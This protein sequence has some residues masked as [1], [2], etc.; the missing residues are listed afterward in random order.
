M[1]FLSLSLLGL[2]LLQGCGAGALPKHSASIAGTPAGFKA[3]QASTDGYQADTAF[4]EQQ[5]ERARRHQLHENTTWQRLVHYRPGVFYGVDSQVDGPAF[6]LS[7]KGPSDPAA[8][9]EATIRGFYSPP[10]AGQDHP[11]CRFPARWLWLRKHLGLSN[12]TLPTVNCAGLATYLERANTRSLTV[13]FSSYYLNNPASMFGHTFLRFN[14]G[15]DGP[16]ENR[17]LLEQGIDYSAAVPESENQL[18]YSFKGLT[19][20]YPG[21]F[22]MLPYYYKVREYNDFESRDLWEYDLA[23]DEEEV[24]MVVT[25]IWELG[26]SYFDYYYLSEN[27]S[28]HVLAAIEAANPRFNMLDRVGWPVIP[29]DTVKALMQE[30]GLVSRVQF[31]PSATS[32]FRARLKS[33]PGKLLPWVVKLG[34]KPATTLPQNFTEIE[35]AQ[36]LDAA[37]DYVEMSYAKEILADERSSKGAGLKQQLLERRAELDAE[38]PDLVVEPPAHEMPHKGHGSSRL[39]V[40]AGVIDPARGGRP[41]SSFF[42]L[43]YRLAL[44]DLSDAPAGYPEFS[45][46]EFLPT[47]LRYDPDRQRIHVEDLSLVR[48]I[49][50]N[51]VDSFNMRP[52]YKVR[53]GAV[54]FRDKRCAECTMGALELG[55]GIAT[56]FLNRA[57]TLWTT[58]DTG[59]YAIRFGGSSPD[60]VRFQVGPSAGVRIR[61]HPRVV[62]VSSV[63]GAVLPFQGSPRLVW[64]ANSILRWQPTSSWSASIE[65][66][67]QPSSTQLML[68]TSLYF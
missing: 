23:L 42:Q 20:M 32:T 64:E 60:K 40:G 34:E 68:G 12:E 67:L 38:T 33:V 30:P 10:V 11:L 61:F 25:H 51:P 1:R 65:G 15:A 58:F 27:C 59:F 39:G 26:H 55:G 46:L 9:L 17:K 57:L 43:D 47:R 66:R 13:V 49:S 44:H 31:R 50:L 36:A 16:E 6:F 21:I 3:G 54:T 19:G 7:P 41:A 4:I 52:S 14:R 53:V 2:A 5:V 29:A 24:A 8:E 62:S 48:V 28:Y 37:I 56:S 18:V 22:R 35:V 63:N 45:Q